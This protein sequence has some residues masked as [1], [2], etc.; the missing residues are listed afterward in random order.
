M[1]KEGT[2][3]EVTE[4]T[5]WCV[6]MVPVVKPNGKIRICVDLRKL[7]EAVK[8]EREIHSAYLRRCSSKASTSQSIFKIRR[9]K[10]LLADTSALSS[11][12]TTFITPSGRLCFRRLPFGITSA[13]EMFQK[14]ITNLLK[15]QRGVAAIQDDIIVDG[16]TVAEHDASLQR[17]LKTIAESG[18]RLNEKKGEIRK[19]KICFFGNV[20]TEKGVSRDPEKVKAIQELPAPK[21]V[22]ELRQ[23][24]GM[25]N[26]LGKFLPNLSDVISPISELLK[27]HSAWNWSQPQMEAFERVKAM[28]TT[29]PVLAFYDVNTD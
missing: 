12:L 19:P 18:L 29:A 24:L 8:R 28:V 3:E 21:N 1:L 7:N 14:T 23:L 22:S 9:I 13:P 25:I 5:D 26:Y 11:K 16:K 17:V 20:I 27:A 2:I 15:D 10:W 4:P 6:P